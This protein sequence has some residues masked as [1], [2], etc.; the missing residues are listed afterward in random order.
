M[1]TP[2]VNLLWGSLAALVGYKVYR[3]LG[4]SRVK[5]PSLTGHSRMAKTFTR[6]IPNY[7]YPDALWLGVDGAEPAVLDRRRRGFRRLAAELAQ[8]SPKTIAAA[9]ASAEVISDAQ[10]IKH[11]RIP[12][13]FRNNDVM[14]LKTGTFW[15]ASQGCR[16]YDLDG[17]EFI[18][19]S[20][21]YGVNL[22]GLDFYKGTMA[23]AQHE[24]NDLGPFLGGYHSSLL[25]AV[26]M[27]LEVAQ[28][29]EVSFH[30]S[31]TE[32][33]MQAVRLARYH[34]G[35]KKIVRFSGA[36]HGWWDDVQPGPG[37]PMPP[38]RHTLTLREVYTPTLDF[39][40]SRSDIACVLVNPIQAM[41]PNRNAPTDALLI[42][43]MRAIHYDREA[44]TQWLKALRE[45]CTE[46]GIVLIFDE[47]FLG[48]RLALGGAQEFFGVQADLVTYG[49]T[50]GGGFPIGVLCG[51]AALMRRFRPDQPA[52]V[53]FAR[54]TFNAHPHVVAGMHAFLKRVTTPEQRAAYKASEALWNDRMQ[55]A[56]RRLA[57]E[58]LPLRFS[59]LP[60]VWA[61]E[62]A[63]AGR[64]H[65]LLQ[66]YLRRA[67]LYLS[68]VGTGRLIFNFGF[69]EADFSEFLD[70]FVTGCRQFSEDGWLSAP[71]GLTA[72]Q[73]RR[74]VL[75]EM[76]AAKFTRP[77]RGASDRPA[78]PLAGKAA[79]GGKA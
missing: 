71:E 72:K 33:V 67:G 75:R 57:Q 45:V 47:V 27:L 65:W 76:I 52:N 12:L 31:G 58:G 22:F 41:H 23:E 68:W 64:Y 69:T 17:Q 70:R 1:D 9:A 39:L 13:Q 7:Q 46:K 77:E 4:L 8:R 25:P 61:L 51:R 78:L 74:S 62:I 56:N 53:C 43:G 34:T 79:N 2:L 50:V 6:F 19:I 28:M 40:R 35:R 55:A 37:N 16:L 42:D 59:G 3:R 32:A 48:F 10:F 24:A 11:N 30:M 63:Q 14:R 54:G 20:G 66:F 15:R 18:D 29:D 26:K 36:Y 60:T 44:Y 38:S 49:K 21:S 73:I 5:H